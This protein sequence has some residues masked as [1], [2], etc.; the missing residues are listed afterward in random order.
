MGFGMNA[1]APTMIY[2]VPADPEQAWFVQGPNRQVAE[3]HYMQCILAEKYRT[4]LYRFVIQL[5]VDQ[6]A[7]Q[8]VSLAVN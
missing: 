3:I 7:E 8:P 4:P 6:Y 1:N 2:S 5:K